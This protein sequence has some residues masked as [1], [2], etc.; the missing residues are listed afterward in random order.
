MRQREWVASTFG[1]CSVRE[2]LVSDTVPLS[3]TFK[4]SYPAFRQSIAASLAA[5]CYGRAHVHEIGL[6]I[7]A[8]YEFLILAISRTLE[9]A[10][11]SSAFEADE[12][13]SGKPSAS[14]MTLWFSICATEGVRRSA[15]SACL[16]R[17]RILRENCRED[18]ATIGT[19]CRASRVRILA[20]GVK[21]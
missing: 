17:V 3:T 16:R 13:Q 10:Q 7:A 1:D 9:R 18:R 11:A 21:A 12:C 5:F 19:V 4:N 20:D 8:T 2:E 6:T 14:P 15:S